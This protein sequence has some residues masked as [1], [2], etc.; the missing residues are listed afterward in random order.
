MI[1]AYAMRQEL[2]VPGTLIWVMAPTFKWLY[3]ATWPALVG[4]IPPE[5][6][7][8]WDAD[9]E[10][11]R[12]INGSLAQFRSL[13]DPERGRGQGP[14]AGWMDEASLIP[15]KA[16]HV[17]R[18]SLTENRGAML[19]TTS[20]RG[21]DWCYERF[22]K[23][24][25][26]DKR[27]GYWAC[28]YKTSDN[29]TIDQDEI[30]EARG[31]MPDAMFR[32][33]YEADF[34]NFTGSVY[35]DYIDKQTLTDLDAIK[36]LL[37]EWPKIDP[38]RKAIRGLDS[39]AD[40]PFGAVHLVAIPPCDAAPLGGLA[41]VADYLERQ[42]AVAQ[43][44]NA[45]QFE[46]PHSYSL[47]WGA[48]KNEAQLRLEMAQHGVLVAPAESNQE[49]GIQ[50]VMSWL[51]SGQLWFIC[52]S[53]GGGCPR[54]AEQMKKL[55]YAENSM[56]DGSKREHEKVYKKADELPDAVR[57]ALM[58][59]PELPKVIVLTKDR[60]LERFDAKTRGDIERVREHNKTGE[61]EDLTPL[62]EGYPVGNFFGTE[63]GFNESW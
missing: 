48:N 23:P 43:H 26:L 17:F 40:H 13:D 59:W 12:L 38:T 46:L 28:K 54:T 29:P 45:I 57:Y 33:E 24:A 10:E 53:T 47:M 41:V 63:E 55:R 52:P 44:L 61:R 7:A 20:P 25:I 35:G 36:K 8:N 56:P 1:G 62:Q 27:Q 32:Q 2:L 49:A 37:P 21:F 9:A 58:L 39:G 14:H 18:P 19:L 11:M 5:W 42:R 4:I 22:Y 51:H 34:V 6:V 3:D 60:S 50:R 31:S 16:W 30:D 15:E